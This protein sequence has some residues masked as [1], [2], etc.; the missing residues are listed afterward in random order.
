MSIKNPGWTGILI[1]ALILTGCLKKPAPKKGAAR[2]YSEPPASMPAG[3]ARF[4]IDREVI[5][6]RSRGEYLDECLRGRE[7]TQHTSHSAGALMYGLS[8]K[9]VSVYAK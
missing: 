8:D 6:C 4:F 2:D 9:P 5:Y 7:G 1:V 3:Y